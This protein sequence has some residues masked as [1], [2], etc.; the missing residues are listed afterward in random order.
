VLP[1][2]AAVE[3][4]EH[5]AVVH[6]LGCHLVEHLRGV[7][8]TGAQPLGEVAVDAAVLL[9]VA[10]GEGEDFLLGKVGEA[11]HRSSPRGH[12]GDRRGHQ[13]NAGSPGTTATIDGT[14]RRYRQTP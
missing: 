2:L 3:I 9:L 1:E 8:E 7:R 6:F 11:L 10:D 4:V 5:A 13:H 14:R 12:H